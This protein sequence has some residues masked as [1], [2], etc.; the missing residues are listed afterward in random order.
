MIGILKRA[1]QFYKIIVILVDLVLINLAIVVAFLLKFEFDLPDFNFSAY[2]SVMPFITI[3]ALVYFDIYG[4]FNFYRKTIYETITSIIF[5]VILLTITTVA[6]AYFGRSFSF[7]RSVLLASPILQILFL[8]T[9][10]IFII[11]IREHVIDPKNVMIVGNTN[12]INDVIDKLKESMKGLN[13]NIRYI[14]DSNDMEAIL[15][16]IKDVEEVFICAGTTD[17][18]KVKIILECLG[19]RRVIYVVPQI[20]EI[21]LLHSKLTQFDDIP[22]FMIDKLDLSIE[23]KFFKRL[24]DISASLL[25]IIITSPIMGIAAMLVKLTSKGPV[26]YTQERVTKD[27]KSF[28]IYKFRTMYNEVEKETGPVISGRDDPR[29]TG[30]GRILRK[31]RIDEL[32]QF[33]NVL[34]GEMSMIGP[35]PERPYFVEQFSREIPEYVHRYV[36]K[37]G[38][39]GYAQVLGKYDTSPE[40][41]LRY[42]LLYVKNYSML[43]DIKLIL[44][45]V[46]VVF[47]GNNISARSFE[48]N[49]RKN[50]KAM[51]F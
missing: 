48:Q 34:K 12:E 50:G 35:R 10:K 24:F 7:P 4:L 29:I 17:E 26:V 15:K 44:Q 45:T 2:T 32:P 3:A 18:Q 36:V 47:T 42:D 41:K 31:T 5:V 23:Q 37:A 33:F 49:L 51:S 9:W 28:N 38:I 13:A 16:R 21:S 1:E 43:L 20:F 39:T 14:I 19:S 30:I 40:D 22:A 6:I 27:N 25:G 11:K 46:K 8:S